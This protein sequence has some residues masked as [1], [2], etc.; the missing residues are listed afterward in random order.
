[1]RGVVLHA[2]SRATDKI[3]TIMRYFDTRR[4]TFATVSTC[5]AT[6]ALGYP[7]IADEKGQPLPF[8][9]PSKL[10]K[11]YMPTE[12]RDQTRRLSERWGRVLY[13]GSVLRE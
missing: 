9:C 1:M 2:W 10:V 3:R 8:L 7:G 4:K 12:L 5:L 11:C 13:M 6:S